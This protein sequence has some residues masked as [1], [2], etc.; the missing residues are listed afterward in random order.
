VHNLQHQPLASNKNIIGVQ[1]TA[2]E[3]PS[4]ANAKRYSSKERIRSLAPLLGQA[5]V[6]GPSPR[7]L[8]QNL[9]P[10]E[11]AAVCQQ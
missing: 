4:I 1:S 6:M 2:Q 11:A 7:S 3:M 10:M 5:M 9:L 8:P